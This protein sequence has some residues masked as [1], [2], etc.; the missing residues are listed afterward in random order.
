MQNHTYWNSSQSKHKQLSWAWT[1]L[2]FLL[3]QSHQSGGAHVLTSLKR[4]KEL[5]EKQ[6]RKLEQEDMKEKRKKDGEDK[7]RET[8]WLAT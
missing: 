8:Q 4:L 3:R 1:F 2:L 7:Q 6:R 5:V